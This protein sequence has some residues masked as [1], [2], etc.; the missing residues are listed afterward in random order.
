MII[1][2]NVNRDGGERTAVTVR[3]AFFKFVNTN[4]HNGDPFLVFES[5]PIIVQ[6]S[7]WNYRC[8]IALG[9]D[10]IKAC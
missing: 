10:M 8:L 2:A 9:I 6:M 3:M 7:I 5:I 1:Y 4:L